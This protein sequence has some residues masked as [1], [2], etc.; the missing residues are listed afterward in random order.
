[1][2]ITHNREASAGINSTGMLLFFWAIWGA[3]VTLPAEIVSI[4][5]FIVIVIA[6]LHGKLSIMDYPILLLVPFPAM[7]IIGLG[8]SFGF[9]SVDII[10]DFWYF[11]LPVVSLLVGWIISKDWSA[12]NLKKH[13]VIVSTVVS[14]LFL[15][16]AIWLISFESVSFVEKYEWRQALGAG[17]FISV[18]GL[19]ILFDLF[20]GKSDEPIFK[21]RFIYLCM[22]INLMAVIVADSRT[23]LV[24][25]FVGTFFVFIP[26]HLGKKRR[27]YFAAMTFGGIVILAILSFSKGDST[28]S[29]GRLQN[30]VWEQFSFSF[31][32]MADIN[33][34]YRAFEALA[35]MRTFLEGTWID[36]MIGFGFGKTIDL[37][38]IMTL[39]I[40][41]EKN[42]YQFVPILH[43][44]Y[45]YILVKTGI[46]GFLLYL[47]FI[48]RTFLAFTRVRVD[49]SKF[50]WP[51]LGITIMIGTLLSTF[52]VSGPFNKGGFF[53]TFLMLGIAL[54]ICFNRSRPRGLDSDM[55]TR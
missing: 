36:Q 1:M 15:V 12:R 46:L 19:F 29:V 26:A 9:S 6:F 2:K 45:I 43:N 28:S 37:G 27:L 17:E 49:P 22:L 55:A 20:Y 25:L 40:P 51:K 3:T 44:G 50:F 4:I 33:Q 54:R 32:D 41:G 34:K 35:G 11:S 23:S 10:K 21:R 52:V 8:N 16:K 42:D 7:I 18:W 38:M 14:C 30:I 47:M 13:L 31:V 53:T 48:V 5:Y 39:G 24:L